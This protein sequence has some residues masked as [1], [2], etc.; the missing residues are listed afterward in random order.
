MLFLEREMAR[1]IAFVLP[2]FSD[3][4]R[5][6][7][8]KLN[9]R[10]PVCGDSKKNKFKAR[11]WFH[12]HKGH[13]WFGCFNCNVNMS[14]VNFMKN[15][16]EEM[17]KEFLKEKYKE[18][19]SSKPNP[20]PIEPKYKLVTRAELDSKFS[21]DRCDLVKRC[22]LL[23][24]EHPVIKW[25]TGRVIP[26]DKHHLF[27]FTGAWKELTNTI[28]P[29]TYRNVEPEYRLVIPIYNADGSFSCMQGRALGNVDK[30]QRYLT[31]KP[32]DDVNKLYGL[33]RIDPTKTVYYFE[34]PIDSVFIPNSLAIV[35]GAMAIQ[36]APFKEK[37]VWVLDNEP[38]SKDTIE[39]LEKLIRAGER[40][41]VWLDCPWA[42]QKDI[43]D[44]ILKSGAT[45]ELIQQYLVENTCSGLSAQ[46]R[47]SEWRKL[48]EPQKRKHDRVD[49][50]A[51][52]RWS[53]TAEV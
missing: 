13:V 26:R 52:L 2:M 46:R 45:A 20:K 47:L 32:D 11:G 42:D 44:M 51:S 31:V 6:D 8:I 17:Y 36:D 30:N 41:V 4:S 3:H 27:Y 21:L 14:L 12:E 43:N 15:Y 24:P 40:V 19:E 23:P 5:P 29:D 28:K 1:Q 49:H 50:S 22:D 39:R 7:A 38:R 18:S 10:C 34:G 53:G 35:G 9:F 25:M 37:R 48:N 16:R 33:E